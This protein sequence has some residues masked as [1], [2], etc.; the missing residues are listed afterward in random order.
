M[1]PKLRV[2]V[3]SLLGAVLF[4]TGAWA[5]NLHPQAHRATSGSSS[6]VPQPAS[7]ERMP[8]TA[9]TITYV[10]GLLTISADNSTLSEILRGIG[11][12]TGAEVDVPLQAEERVVTH[13]GPGLAHEVVQALLTG[14]RFNYIIVG[15]NE[16]P[17]GVSKILLFPVVVAESAHQPLV[18]TAATMPPPR[19]ERTGG[20]IEEPAQ[21]EN[22]SGQPVLPAR[23]FQQM[24]QQRGQ[25]RLEE[26]QRKQQAE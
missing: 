9:P 5:Q 20:D 3:L 4:V 13:L 15:S 12:Q 14:S 22:I 19:I 24:L 25:A 18:D 8:T 17:N 16:D 10:N 1:Y 6:A 26:F 2:T 23:G 11:S 21:S 7:L